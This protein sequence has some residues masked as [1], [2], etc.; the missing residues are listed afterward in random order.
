MT[1]LKILLFLTSSIFLFGFA[2]NEDNENINLVERSLPK[3]IVIFEKSKI[4][5]KMQDEV[6][7]NLT[8]THIDP[9]WSDNFE[10]HLTSEDPDTATV[11]KVIKPV[12]VNKLLQSWK[13]NFTITGKFIGRDRIFVELHRPNL[14]VEK[15][16]ESLQVIV[17]RNITLI[18]N[19]FTIFVALFVTVI[20]INFGA[21]LDLTVL[22]QILIRPV[23]PAIGFVGQF[24]IMPVLSFFIGYILFPELIELRLGLFFT[25][26]SPGGGTS[27]IFTVIFNG[28]LDLSIIMTAVSNIAALAMMPLWIFTLGALIFHDGNFAIPYDKIAMF[29]ISLIL[30]LGVGV[31]LQKCT[32]KFAAK[33]SKGLKPISISLIIFISICAMF[34]NSYLFKLFSWKVCI[35]IFFLSIIL[36][37]V[38]YFYCFYYA[39]Y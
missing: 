37:F 8:I 30:P 9:K 39:T 13:G 12:E 25:G 22:K 34:M 26:T 27:N 14:I 11:R 15:S 28:N 33:L 36:S 32:P 38:L 23:G 16:R 1:F 35:I 24:L 2:L 19:L 4:K 29:S 20:Y 5:L 18:D 6:V 21:A 3:W 31:M 17:S 10:F 7:V